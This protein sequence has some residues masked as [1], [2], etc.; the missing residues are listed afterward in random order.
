MTSL[1][2]ATFCQRSGPQ[3]PQG[4]ALAAPLAPCIAMPTPVASTARAT[5]CVALRISTRTQPIPLHVELLHDVQLA[6]ESGFRTTRMPPALKKRHD[7]I[8]YQVVGQQRRVGDGC[9]SYPTRW[10]REYV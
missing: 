10:R 2:D 9:S 8:A 3:F 4:V 7:L 6:A 5:P 1:R